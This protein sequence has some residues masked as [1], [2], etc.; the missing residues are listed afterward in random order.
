MGKKQHDEDQEPGSSTTG[1]LTKKDNGKK[2]KKEKN[3]G[4]NDVPRPAHK[5]S[6]KPVKPKTDEVVVA[7]AEPK[8]DKKALAK[9]AAKA[10][11]E[12]AVNGEVKSEVKLPKVPKPKVKITAEPSLAPKVE[13]KEVAP[14]PA[15]NEQLYIWTNDT[16]FN[17][18]VTAFNSE[19][20]KVHFMAALKPTY[21]FKCTKPY[22]YLVIDKPR[23]QT[24]KVG[25]ELKKN[26]ASLIFSET[27]K[28]FKFE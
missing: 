5:T 19:N 2:D 17:L 15:E 7:P 10:A 12:V 9:A 27:V 6:S 25:S 11:A 28:M 23:K 26:N 13:E 22:S 20:E 24:L 16:E 14:K 4:K 18:S 3:K 1:D 8:V 21:L